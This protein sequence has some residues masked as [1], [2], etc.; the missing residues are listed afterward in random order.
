[1]SLRVVLKINIDVFYVIMLL[2]LRRCRELKVYMTLLYFR[3]NYKFQV[4]LSF[5][6]FW[7]GSGGYAD[8]RSGAVSTTGDGEAFVKLCFAKHVSMLMEQGQ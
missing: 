4:S 1:M 8:N 6:S 3:S 5:L 7:T 2:A